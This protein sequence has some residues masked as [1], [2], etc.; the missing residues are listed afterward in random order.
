[1]SE[2]MLN[3]LRKNFETGGL[4]PAGDSRESAR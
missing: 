1:M 3:R 4:C 2:L